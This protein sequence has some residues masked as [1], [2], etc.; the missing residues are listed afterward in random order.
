MDLPYDQSYLIENV[1]D[2]AHIHIAHHGMRGGGSR[3]A[4]KPLEFDL[5]ESSIAGIRS[6]FRSVGLVRGEHSPAL[7]GATVEFVAPNLVRYASEYRDPSLVA[8]LELYS[9]PLSNNRC[10]LLYRKY[11]NFTSVWERLK[12]RWMEHLTQ[13]T[14]LEQDMAVVVG[15]SEQIDR[16]TADLRELWLPL[17][18]SDYLVVEY[19]KWLDR[20]GRGLPFY[21]GFATHR[22]RAS[23]RSDRRLPA[24]RH[25]L[26]TRVCASCS[27]LYRR[28]DLAI[29]ALWIV[30]AVGFAVGL[31]LDSHRARVAVALAALVGL[32]A[33]AAAR[34]FKS[35][36]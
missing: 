16:A 6:R 31:M 34:R 2:V 8:G 23:G 1:I 13:C 36:F 21:R 7:R 18:T 33:I 11:S 20:F 24:D 32:L 35:R 26:H 9:L 10:R 19:R 27:R 30:V 12:P 15:Q 29:K 4:A 5:E 3:E 28:V 17:K 25:V 22:F 14:I